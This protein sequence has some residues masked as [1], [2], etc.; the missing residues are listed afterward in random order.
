MAHQTAASGWKIV[1]GILL[2]LSLTAGVRAQP[3][4]SVAPRTAYPYQ[5]PIRRSSASV[6]RVHAGDR[7]FFVQQYN[8]P[9]FGWRQV[10]H[11][12][13]SDKRIPCGR[14]SLCHL[15][16]AFGSPR[17]ILSSQDWKKITANGLPAGAAVTCSQPLITSCTAL[18]LVKPAAT[19]STLLPP[20]DARY[21]RNDHDMDQSRCR[22]LRRSA[23]SYGP[24]YLGVFNHRLVAITTSTHD[25]LFGDVLTYLDG[26]EVWESATAISIAGH[27][28]MRMALANGGRG[29]SAFACKGTLQF[30][31]AASS[32]AFSMSAQSPIRARK[33]GGMMGRQRRLDR[34]YPAHPRHLLWV[35]AG[36]VESMMVFQRLMS[37]RVIPPPTSTGMIARPGP[38]SKAAPIL[39]TRQIPR[40]WHWP[41]PSCS[42]TGDKLYLQAHVF[43]GGYQVWGHAF[44]ATPLTCSALQQAT[45]S[46]SPKAATNELGT[47]GQT[48]TVT[49]TVNAGIG[50]DF[51][52]LF[53]SGRVEVVQANS[54]AS[55][56]GFAGL[57]GLLTFSYPALQGPIGL[58]T[59]TITA[60]FSPPGVAKWRYRHQNLGGYHRAQDHRQRS[61]RWGQSCAQYCGAG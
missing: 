53:I 51:S 35:G 30:G 33:S 15:F 49:A 19:Q 27:R 32:T 47:P 20:P 56:S 52:D 41:F 28:S 54:V 6:R 18:P 39:L 61:S 57:N 3:R 7:R 31:R 13:R 42:T 9:C 23:E 2:L 50:A 10:H 43:G 34:R 40:S 55:A 25:G 1:V 22:R 24:G 45:I 59:D 36:R 5:L 12:I 11:S 48:H 58:H 16:R 8:Q 60:C 26:I 37:P 4:E 14:L 17:G 21:R 44:A 46:L 29:R 38:W